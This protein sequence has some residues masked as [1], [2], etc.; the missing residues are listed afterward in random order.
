MRAVRVYHGWA[1]EV[2]YVE[3]YLGLN[4]FLNGLNEP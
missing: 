2:Y 4:L 1:I 3:T